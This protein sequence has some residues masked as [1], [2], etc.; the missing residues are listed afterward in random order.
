MKIK[1]NIAISE[2]GFIFNPISGESFS[3]NQTGVV[4]LNLLKEEVGLES[5][6]S[7]ICEEYTCENS[8]VDKDVRDFIHLLREYNLLEGDEKN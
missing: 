3:V 1:S 2:A 5:L 8:T 4:L 6:Q 7:A